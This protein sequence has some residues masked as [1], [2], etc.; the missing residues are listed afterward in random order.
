MRL[1]STLEDRSGVR[2]SHSRRK[3]PVKHF[4]LQAINSGRGKAGRASMRP[5]VSHTA[6]RYTVK[7]YTA[8]QT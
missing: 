6:K 2:E 7:G 1:A 3:L 5:T 4:T 8:K